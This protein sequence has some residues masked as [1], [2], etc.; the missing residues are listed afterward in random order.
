VTD[1]SDEARRFEELFRSNYRAVLA[2]ALRRADP[3][4]ADEVVAD[5]FLVCWRRLDEVPARALPW[6]LG[7]A[8]R[9]LANRRRG[10]APPGVPG[11]ARGGTERVAGG[12]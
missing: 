6:L 8:R 1:Q 7:V 5:T 10:P 3:E 2:Y 4:T 9:C 11:G 12:G